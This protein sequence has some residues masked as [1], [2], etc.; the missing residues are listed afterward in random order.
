MSVRQ[1]DKKKQGW[2]IPGLVLT[3]LSILRTVAKLNR[4]LYF[5]CFN[6]IDK[7]SEIKCPTLIIHGTKDSVVEIEDGELLSK[8]FKKESLYEF[9]KIDNGEHNDLY[10]NYKSIIFNSILSL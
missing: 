7:V 1:L 10:K 5:D 2:H 3:F 6:N 8:S 4:T 9:I